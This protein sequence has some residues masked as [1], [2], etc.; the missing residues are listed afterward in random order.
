MF[1]PDGKQYLQRWLTYQAERRAE[2]NYRSLF[3]RTG[4]LVAEANDVSSIFEK[5][6]EHV[7]PAIYGE[8]VPTVGKAL[9]AGGEGYD[10]VILIGPFNCLPYR[11]SEAILKPLSLQRGMPMLSYESDGYAVSPS[12]LRQVEVHVQQVL[13]HA[14]GSR[15]ARENSSRRLPDFLRAAVEKLT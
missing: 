9:G 5:A 1:Q 12:V 8:V 4:L 6:A 7:S 13:A 15:A 14:A 10:G 3:S 2:E 11:V